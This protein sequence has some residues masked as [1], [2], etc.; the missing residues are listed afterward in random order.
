MRAVRPPMPMS[1]SSKTSVGTRSASASAVL[2]ASITRESSP[3]EATR[4]SGRG[5]TP[6]LAESRNSARSTPRSSAR[7]RRPSSG[8]APRR[9]LLPL[10]P[11]LEAAAPHRER[12]QLLEDAF[13]EPRARRL[14]AAGEFGGER[15]GGGS[16]G[17][18]LPIES[19]RAAPTPAPSGRFRPATAPASARIAS[20]VGPYFFLRPRDERQPVL[21]L[22][23]AAPGRPRAAR[24][25]PAARAPRPR[26]RPAPRRARRPAAA[27]PDRR[28]RPRRDGGPRPRRRP[29]PRPRRSTPAPRPRR[30]RAAS[31]STLR[32]TSRSDAQ[33]LLLAGLQR[34]AL[35]LLVLEAQD[36]PGAAPA[37]P[38][39]ARAGRARARARR[40][41]PR[42]RGSARAPRAA[43]AKPSR[44]SRWVSARS[45]DW[46]WCWPWMS[47]SSRP[48]CLERRQRDRRVV[49]EGAAA[50][51]RAHHAPQQQLVRRGTPAASSRAEPR[52]GAGR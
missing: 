44:K 15:G 27:A 18:D 5:S 36:T 13:L 22:L 48:I 43:A 34:R 23:R 31:R 46:C 21:D 9:V 42:P 11:D 51:A 16:G 3:P 37:P 28:R 6:G 52:A 1:T 40:A 20:T 25:S 35:E 39:A 2:S 4:A 24:G 33:P 7:Q 47:T 17:G 26:A 10:Q 12:G 45:S 8:Q 50:P 19:R 30:R 14:A 32:R 29:R 41:A 38:P 49:R